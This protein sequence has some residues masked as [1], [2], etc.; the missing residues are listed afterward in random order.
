[1]FNYLGNYDSAFNI[2]L[3]LWIPVSSI[4]KVS[5]SWI[6]DIGFNPHLHKKP[7]GVLV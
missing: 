3:R 4:G 1:M 6:R 2:Y 7:T 5:D